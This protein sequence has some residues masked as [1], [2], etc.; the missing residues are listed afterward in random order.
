MS[1]SGALFDMVKLFDVSKVHFSFVLSEAFKYSHV[2]IACATYNNELF[3]N[4][5]NFLSEV[6]KHNLQNRTF[7]FIENGSWACNSQTLAQAKLE[8]LKGDGLYEKF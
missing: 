7:A 8:K 3:V 4:M 2:V 1:V 5:D 6:A